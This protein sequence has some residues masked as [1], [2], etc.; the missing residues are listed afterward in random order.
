MTISYEFE[1]HYL[2]DWA[3]YG[4]LPVW[5]GDAWPQ[6]GKLHSWYTNNNGLKRHLIE[7]DGDVFNC[8]DC[9]LRYSTLEDVMGEKPEWASEFVV[10]RDGHARWREV[11]DPED[12][13]MVEE[14]KG[15]LFDPKQYPEPIELK[16]DV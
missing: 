11:F 16:E 14:I 2:P 8:C 3:P 4:G 15:H 13:P 10:L 6:E 5:T 9:K 7:L 1:G 12:F